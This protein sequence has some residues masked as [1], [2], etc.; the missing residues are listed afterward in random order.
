MP[1]NSIS[2]TCFAAVADGD[3]FHDAS[4]KSTDLCYHSAPLS[5][6]NI[7]WY[8]TNNGF[9]QGGHWT[10]VIGN[11]CNTLIVKCYNS[12]I[13]NDTI[14]NKLKM[15]DFTLILIT[16]RAVNTLFENPPFKYKMAAHFI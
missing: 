10:T 6:E 1:C 5:T 16:C 8:L 11:Y 15:D 4:I 3:I 13:L 9:M 7:K 14:D 2:L 12:S